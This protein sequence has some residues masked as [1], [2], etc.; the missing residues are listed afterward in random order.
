MRLPA[1]ANGSQSPQTAV[2]VMFTHLTGFEPGTKNMGT[3]SVV[4]Y[5]WR[6]GQSIRPGTL[7]GRSAVVPTT[8][9][10]V[11]WSDAI[12]SA[13]GKGIST[14]APCLDRPVRRHHR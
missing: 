4:S 9:N 7:T 3:P 10:L 8:I 11:A 2:P 14:V 5:I 1:T 12:V 6:G 13:L